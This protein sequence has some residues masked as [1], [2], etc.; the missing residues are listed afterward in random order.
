MDRVP[1]SVYH[2]VVAFPY[3]SLYYWLV[4]S[5][6]HQYHIWF[7]VRPS[8]VVLLVM[9]NSG[10]L[11]LSKIF[12]KCTFTSSRI[13]DILYFPLFIVTCTQCHSYPS[14]RE[15]PP[16][17]L[18]LLLLL[19][20]PFPNALLWSD[21][22]PSVIREQR[23]TMRCS[24]QLPNSPHASSGGTGGGAGGWQSVWSINMKYSVLNIHIICCCCYPPPPLQKKSQGCLGHVRQVCSGDSLSESKVKGRAVLNGAT[25]TT[26]G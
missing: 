11:N 8:E 26:G 14:P 10:T 5:V 2:S 13:D 16:P 6:I 24:S 12:R 15:P 23:E 22:A 4:I 17:N 18:L 21:D 7:T 1:Y 25:S 9:I 20:P 19:A 3:N